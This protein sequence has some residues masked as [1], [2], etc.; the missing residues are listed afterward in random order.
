MRKRVIILAAFGITFAFVAFA[1]EPSKV[2][3]R[4]RV[5]GR[6]CPALAIQSCP[7]TCATWANSQPDF[8]YSYDACVATCRKQFQC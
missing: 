8:Q 7:R 4:G 2:S 5:E 3:N 1:E 6:F